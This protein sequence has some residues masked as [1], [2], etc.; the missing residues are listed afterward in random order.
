MSAS[1]FSSALTKQAYNINDVTHV[2]EFNDMTDTEKID[3]IYELSQSGLTGETK[4]QITSKEDVIINDESKIDG[5]TVALTTDS[6]AY[7]ADMRTTYPNSL[8][9]GIMLLASSII[10]F[11]VLPI[12][13]SID[14]L[15]EKNYDF[16]MFE[17][18]LYAT[19]ILTLFF[20]TL[21]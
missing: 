8:I 1:A 19:A 13:A 17:T 21:M 2:E 12:I 5:G 15:S 16:L 14:K 20:I 3:G 9:E 6:G 18:F 10:A 11:L 4:R 7:I